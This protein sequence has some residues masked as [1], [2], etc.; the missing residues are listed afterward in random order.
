[1]LLNRLPRDEAQ[2]GKRDK[3]QQKEVALRLFA[4]AVKGGPKRLV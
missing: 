2:A 4:F 1:M 3:R